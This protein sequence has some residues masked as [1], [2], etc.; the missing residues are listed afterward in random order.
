VSDQWTRH[1]LS[2]WCLFH[3]LCRSFDQSST[4]RSRCTVPS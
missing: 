3:A 1:S 4:P 2:K